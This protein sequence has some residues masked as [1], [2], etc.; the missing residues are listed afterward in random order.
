MEIG[1]RCQGA[2]KNT[3][4][5][6]VPLACTSE[7]VRIVN[8]VSFSNSTGTISIT[9]VLAHI[10]E[11]PSAAYRCIEIHSS[12]RFIEHL[13]EYPPIPTLYGMSSTSSHTNPSSQPMD[14]IH[15]HTILPSAQPLVRL[16]LTRVLAS[17]I[18]LIHLS[19]IPAPLA[20]SV[21]YRVVRSFPSPMDSA[22]D[23]I[24]STTPLFERYVGL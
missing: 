10:H 5:Y 15:I 16:T 9:W 19:F 12:L 23:S 8:L 20:Q 24:L 18:S 6:S 4:S 13:F 11:G 21:P 17:I 3:A 14:L 2:A 1:E 7:L 22:N